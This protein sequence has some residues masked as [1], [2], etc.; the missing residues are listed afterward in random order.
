M[1]RFLA[2][3][4]RITC[5]ACAADVRFI[6]TDNVKSGGI[7]TASSTVQCMIQYMGFAFIAAAED[8]QKV[9]LRVG[10]VINARAHESADKLFVQEIDVGDTE[11]R[12]VV[13]G[14]AGFIPLDSLP[15]RLV[16]CI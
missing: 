2:T 13:S 5:R 15:G 10:K 12:T 7:A 9:D 8:F 4:L 16:V 3:N 14:I 6:A 11:H 1:L